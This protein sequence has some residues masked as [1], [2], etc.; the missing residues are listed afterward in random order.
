[1]IDVLI[2]ELRSCGVIC[3]AVRVVGKALHLVFGKS[4]AFVLLRKYALRACLETSELRYF[5][6]ALGAKEA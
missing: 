3:P 4:G 5:R 6:H 1:M 2:L